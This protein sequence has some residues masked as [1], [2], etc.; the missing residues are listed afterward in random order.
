MSDAQTLTAGEH[1]VD[2]RIHAEMTVF[3]KKR[4]VAGQLCP[5]PPPTPPTNDSGLVHAQHEDNGPRALHSVEV[6]QLPQLAV[7]QPNGVDDLEQPLFTDVHD[8]AAGEELQ[9]RLGGALHQGRGQVPHQAQ[10]ARHQLSLP[11][12]HGSHPRTHGKHG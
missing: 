6:V 5:P 8:T 7:R 3:K 4:I 11:T 9:A 12:R 2:G 1:S 10:A